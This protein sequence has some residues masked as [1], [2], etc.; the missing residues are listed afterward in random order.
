MREAIEGLVLSMGHKATTYD[1][2]DQFLKLEGW[3]DVSCIVTDIQMP[4]QSGLDLQRALAADG[5]A[6]PIIFI[7]ALPR[8]DLRRRAVEAGSHGFLVKPFEAEDLIRCIEEAIK[9]A[10]RVS[11]EG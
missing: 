8:E 2:A 3:D 10:D 6:T 1:S 7:T 9:R 5:V 11:D 4:G